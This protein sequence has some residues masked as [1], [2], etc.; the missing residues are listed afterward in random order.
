MRFT[1]FCVIV[2]VIVMIHL[3]PLSGQVKS[4]YAYDSGK[5]S[6]MVTKTLELNKTVD[7]TAISAKKD[8]LILYSD[9]QSPKSE[10]TLLGRLK[11]KYH[12]L[13]YFFHAVFVINFFFV[14]GVVILSIVIL[15]RRLNRGFQESKIDKCRDRYQNFITDWLYDEKG[16]EIPAQLKEELKDQV[17]RDYFTS[18]LLSLHAH[19]S[20][21]SADSLVQLYLES[22][23]KQYSVFKLNSRLWHLKAK[24]FRELSQMKIEESKSLIS[25]Y[26]NSPND[27]LR[28][29]AQLAWIRLNP[30]NPLSFYDDP[31]I[32]LTEWGQL[33][34][35]NSL[36]KSGVIPEFSKWL[37]SPN[38]SVVRYALKMIGIYQQLHAVDGVILQLDHVDSEIRYTA[39]QTLG[40]M[41]VPST[42]SKLEELFPKE[43]LGNKIEIVSSLMLMFDPIVATF[44]ENIL[45]NESDTGLR[46]VAAKALY[47]LGDSGAERLGILAKRDDQLLNLII[48]HAKDDRI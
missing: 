7:S 41:A 32:Q 27:I 21:E 17:L 13:N 11:S 5:G 29:E 1:A 48:I 6:K 40:K 20:G 34:S 31:D 3:D 43:N 2:F 4:D 42:I 39:I 14:F 12:R 46:T 9:P 38:K 47:S 15:F 45:V 8:F 10:V 30:N 26:L 36:K 24:G 22:G 23:L 33:N 35:L 37:D 25:P 16:I 18:E 44:I 19:L 28:I